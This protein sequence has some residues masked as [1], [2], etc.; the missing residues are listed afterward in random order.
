MSL[1]YFIKKI[2]NIISIYDSIENDPD[3]K[4][5]IDHIEQK[6]FSNFL[7]I[8]CV[9]NIDEH[10]NFFKYN[11]KNVNFSKKTE[12]CKLITDF[13]KD[14]IYQSFNIKLSDIIYQSVYSII[15]GYMVDEFE[16]KHDELTSKIKDIDENFIVDEFNE[17]DDIEMINIEKQNY[18]NLIIHNF[19]LSFVMSI[20][21]KYNKLI[22]DNSV[23]YEFVKYEINKDEVLELF[24]YINSHLN[25]NKSKYV[26][27][28]N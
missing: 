27:I 12:V 25:S 16:N 23:N 28:L 17:N 8:I 2:N 22:F 20:T 24:K 9:N 13:F 5:I 15:L 14:L 1:K 11:F 4:N 18:K 26:N 19:I 6:G 21:E 3:F 7:S 10:L